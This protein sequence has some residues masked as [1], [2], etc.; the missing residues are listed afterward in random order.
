MERERKVTSAIAIPHCRKRKLK[1]K[2]KITKH[3]S[4]HVVLTKV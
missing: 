1:N 2:V 3:V 4:V